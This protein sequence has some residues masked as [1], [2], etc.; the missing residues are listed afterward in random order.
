MCK[1]D[2][3]THVKEMCVREMKEMCKRRHVKE[4]CE[5]DMQVCEGEGRRE[6]WRCV[7][8]TC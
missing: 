5:G 8:E 3:Q 1:A 2:V 6:A 4:M 7:W